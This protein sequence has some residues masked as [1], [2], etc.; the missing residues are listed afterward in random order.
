MIKRFF[1]AST[2]LF[3]VFILPVFSQEKAPDTVLPVEIN[4]DEINYL[5]EE[6]AVV[7]K[8]NVKLRY[9][10]VELTCDEARYNANTHVATMKGNVKIVREGT[11]VHGESIIYDFN[12]QNAQI[13]NLRMESP[14]LYG[15]AKEADRIGSEQYALKE[16]Y[17][18][19]CNLEKPHYRL[20][21]KK[22]IAYPGVKVVA[23]N[24]V[25]RVGEV[26]IFYF[27]YYSHSLK[28]K[29]FPLQIVP[30]KKSDWGY[31]V[32]GRWNYRLNDEHRGR[33][34]L[35]WYEK[36]GVATGI[37]HKAETKKYGEAM[38]N[39]YHITDQLYNSE[40]RGDL[41][42]EYPERQSL[43]DKYLDSNRYKGQLWHNWQ[44]TQNFSTK[45]EFNKFSDEN[46]MKDF[47][48]REYEIDPN[49]MT[50][51]LSAYA[52]TNSALSLL[53]QKR[54][55]KFF[56]T[57]EYLP[58]LDYDFYKQAL[59]KSNIYF[60]SKSTFSYLN[61]TPA[62]VALA[63]ASGRAN[64]HNVFS[65]PKNIKWL[66]L[67]PYVGNYATFYTKTVPGDTDIWR[68]APEFG[69]DMSTKLYRIFSTNLNVFG[70][71]VQQVRHIFSPTISYGYIHPPTIAKAKIF[72][73]DN[74]DDL[75]RKE[76]VTVAFSNKLQAK[77]AERVWDFLYFS[78]SVE[79][80]VNNKDRLGNLDRGGSHLSKIKSDLEIYP[81][82]G[83][84]LNS[85]T[86]YDCVIKAFKAA[87]VDVSFSDT[88]NKKYTVSFGHRYAREYDYN[89]DSGQYTS[90]STFDLTYQLTK[91]LQFKNY[92]RYEY[93][94]GNFEEQQ[95]AL[96]TDLHCWWMDVGIDI[97]RQREGV[98]DFT[99]WVA[100]IL[101]DFPDMN[102]GF[103][104]GYKGAKESY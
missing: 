48:K 30:G 75:T 3:L 68:V 65:Y 69:M 73:F 74:I 67:S 52:F 62:N 61:Y 42:N 83:V 102:I 40:K 7:V 37:A 9:K 63:Y 64:S 59:G 10:D 87:N 54:V 92:L 88:K 72:Q 38:V 5:Q 29:S 96:R 44:P 85:D 2:F 94:E 91:K 51:N 79:Y 43:P 25:M 39:Y 21:A 8:N 55:N 100:F 82:E 6:G 34:I 86:E 99:F 80:R 1:T 13:A 41:F 104:Q 66:Y 18:S 50:Y 98:N 78:P 4:G 76:T 22:I 32:L 77:N 56:T 103:R 31:Y 93:K 71:K 14:P 101:K 20:T 47:F 24:V 17:V 26:P 57:T 12:T 15:V 49:P 90:Q 89:V 46:F 81:I 60:Q 19:T 53:T 33:L 11:T 36:R 95:Y 27:P 45:T 35:D 16:G 58:Q 97:D 70:T 84:A 23:K 28:Q